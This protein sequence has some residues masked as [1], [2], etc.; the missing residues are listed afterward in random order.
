LTSGKDSKINLEVVEKI[1]RSG[2]AL[3]Q[4][5]ELQK[6]AEEGF[7]NLGKEEK[8]KLDQLFKDTYDEYEKS[9]DRISTQVGMQMGNSIRQILFGLCATVPGAFLVCNPMSIAT[10]FNKLTITAA[11]A[12]GEFDNLYS[13]LI[14]DPRFKILEKISI[15]M[16]DYMNALTEKLKSKAAALK[17]N[18]PGIPEISNVAQKATEEIRGAINGFEYGVE[19]ADLSDRSNSFAAKLGRNA[20]NRYGQVANVATIIKEK[21][22]TGLEE[23]I[24]RINAKKEEFESRL[25][26]HTRKLPAA[27]SSVPDLPKGGGIRKSKKVSAY[28]RSKL[29]HRI[30]KISRR[31][32]KSIEYFLNNRRDKTRKIRKIRKTR[33]H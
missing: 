28:M 33:R 8:E 12:K 19:N 17:F 29:Y 10:L 9:R 24:K 31:T 22:N 13:G 4:L 15:P 32:D 25:Q 11:L 27:S 16:T 2:E 21:F 7:N 18:K 20:G 1:L 6:A 23:A 5:S 3:G 14:N 26:E 30:N